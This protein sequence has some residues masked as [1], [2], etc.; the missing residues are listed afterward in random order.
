M[1]SRST[2]IRR[3]GHSRRKYRV[4]WSRCVFRS[5]EQ[6]KRAVDGRERPT[7]EQIAVEVVGG[8][9]GISWRDEYGPRGVVGIAAR[10]PPTR[11]RTVSK[12]RRKG[13]ALHCAC[14]R[15]FLASC[16][17]ALQPSWDI[18]MYLLDGHPALL[19]LRALV[20]L[21]RLR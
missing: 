12:G 14:G 17:A 5:V 13:H 4:V 16:V 18:G 20:V 21:R 6:E 8:L 15:T 9:Y 2:A 7:V 19:L 1:A 11:R 10:R 3:A